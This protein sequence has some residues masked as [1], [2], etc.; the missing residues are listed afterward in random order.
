MVRSASGV[1]WLRY[2]TMRRLRL[3][4]LKLNDGKYLGVVYPVFLQENYAHFSRV[5]LIL[6]NI[7]YIVYLIKLVIVVKTIKLTI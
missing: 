1:I 2:H 4:E 5:L 6:E 7:N 3:T